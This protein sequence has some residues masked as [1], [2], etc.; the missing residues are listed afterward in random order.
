MSVSTY[1]WHFAMYEKTR[2]KSPDSGIKYNI[3]WV[4]I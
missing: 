4:K 1:Q 2:L 3:G